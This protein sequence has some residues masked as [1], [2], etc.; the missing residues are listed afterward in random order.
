MGIITK[1]LTQCVQGKRV[2]DFRHEIFHEGERPLDYTVILDNLDKIAGA[3]I[4]KADS[5]KLFLDNGY[6]VKFGYE[7]GGIR[8]FA[9]ISEAGI[10]KKDK[11][12][13]T[14]GFAFIFVFDDNSGLVISTN[15][16]SG[17]FRVLGRDEYAPPDKISPY[18]REKYT[19][20]AFR[21]HFRKNI[22]VTAVCVTSKGFLA[23]D[24]GLMHEAL[25]RSGIHPKTKAS[26]LSEEKVES[27]YNAV[28]EIAD[29]VMS[30]GGKTGDIDLFGQPGTYEYAMSLKAVGRPCPVCGAAVKKENAFFSSIFFCPGC[31][32]LL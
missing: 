14:G 18:D 3:V 11:K 7:N 32:R 2:K 31:Q 4:Q 5:E 12:F 22:G 19:L 13:I 29:E 23:V 9:D 10:M 26:K 6:V 17:S 15:S 27:L 30:C 8:Y 28:K 21:P 25:F 16:W 24:R 20:G 1:Q